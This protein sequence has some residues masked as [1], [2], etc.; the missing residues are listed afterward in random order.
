MFFFNTERSEGSHK[1]GGRFF[2]FADPSL[3]LRASAQ[4]FG[5][6]SE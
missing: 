2:P 4:G 6:E 3:K 5:S 1:R